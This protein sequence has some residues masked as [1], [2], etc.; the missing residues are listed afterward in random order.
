MKIAGRN[1]MSKWDDKQLIDAL[2]SGNQE[3]VVYFF[4][5]KFS[6][7]FQYHIYS[8]FKYRE[9]VN[10]LVDEF[11]LYM[12]QDNWRRLRTFDPSKSSLAT[13]ISTVSFRFFKNYKTGKVDC[14]GV[15]TS[16][17]NWG[18]FQSSWTDGHSAAIVMDLHTA[19]DEI[20]SERDRLIAVRIFLEDKDFESVAKEFDLSVDY[21]YTLKNRLVKHL[22]LSLGC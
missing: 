5:Q 21:V 4:Y 2:L 20:K 16:T 19:I 13:W 17:D 9:N 11:F 10:E 22:R 18:K 3:A 14:N 12:Y 1:R 15:I 7:T 6:P 8:L